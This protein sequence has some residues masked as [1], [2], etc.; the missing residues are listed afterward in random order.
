MALTQTHVDQGIKLKTHTKFQTPMDTLF[1]IKMQK[2][3]SGKRQHLQQMMMAKLD[4]C[5]WKN[6][7]R[8]YLSSCTKLN[9]K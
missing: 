1:F 7:N 8:P 4:G 5:I 2:I 9:S 3:H 6:A